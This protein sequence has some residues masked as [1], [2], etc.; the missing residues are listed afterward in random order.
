[1][2]LW[3]SRGAFG[4]S[5]QGYIIEVSAH[6]VVNLVIGIHCPF[7]GV[8]DGTREASF[9]PLGEE[10]WGEFGVGCF[11]YPREV[12]GGSAIHVGG[13][14]D[15]VK[16]GGETFFK[17]DVVADVADLLDDRPSEWM[18]DVQLELDPPVVVVVLSAADA[19]FQGGYAGEII[20]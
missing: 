20:G 10:K 6:F 3:C 1:M 18:G 16:P 19:G 13:W 11:D 17:G 2:M 12:G 14:G 9:E 4:W 15:R 5:V 7:S 8:V